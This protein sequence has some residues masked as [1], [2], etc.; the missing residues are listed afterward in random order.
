LTIDYRPH[1]HDDLTNLAAV[2]VVGVTDPSQQVELDL[3]GDGQFESIAIASTLGEFSVS[4]VTLAEGANTIAARATN[5]RGTSQADLMIELETQQPTAELLNPRHHSF[6]PDGPG[7]IEIRWSDAGPAGLDTSTID[8]TDITVTGV[9]IDR[10]EQLGVGLVRYWYSDD[11]EHLPI[12]RVTIRLAADA[13]SDLAGNAPGDLTRFQIGVFAAWQNPVFAVDVN[14]DWLVEPLDA[15]QVIN[16]INARGNGP[17]SVPPVFPDVP[18]PFLDTSGDNYLEPLDVLIVINYL[19]ANG[20]GPV[21]DALPANLAARLVSPGYGEAESEPAD[22]QEMSSLQFSQASVPFSA[23]AGPG[24]PL[25]AWEV[26][27]RFDPLDSDMPQYRRVE[28]VPTT[29]AAPLGSIS[30]GAKRSRIAGGRREPDESLDDILRDVFAGPRNWLEFEDT[31]EDIF[32]NVY[33]QE[34]TKT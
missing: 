19:N 31:L 6:M 26:R 5:M 16:R 32:P 4:G 2:D 28:A 13:V 3:D 29:S 7:Y 14:A 20:N 12:G 33:A 15:L 9:S 23:H 25:E 30:D 1:A 27:R 8:T 22:N 17:L 21:P 34:R 10:A 18:P 24:L 11:S